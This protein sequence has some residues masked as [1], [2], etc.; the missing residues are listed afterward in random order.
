[1]PSVCNTNS[2]NYNKEISDWGGY[3]FTLPELDIPF[4]SESLIK[5][6][7]QYEGIII[8]RLR[9]RWHNSAQPDEYIALSVPDAY[10]LRDFLIENL[11]DLT[12]MMAETGCFNDKTCK[13][14]ANFQKVYYEDHVKKLKDRIKEL[15][16]KLSK[17]ETEVS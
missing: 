7:T 9:S 2:S 12:Y 1:M 4:S 15:E 3:L 13:A 14:L 11:D 10:Q 8:E 17:E 6:H 5:I 16:E